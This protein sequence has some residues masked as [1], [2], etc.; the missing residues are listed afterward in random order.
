M[1]RADQTTTPAGSRRLAP[2]WALGEGLRLIR[3]NVREALLYFLAIELAT[4]IVVSPLIT[5]ALYRLLALTGEPVRLNYGLLDLLLEPRLLIGVLWLPVL[6]WIAMLNTGGLVAMT[7]RG[8]QQVRLSVGAAF[9]HTLRCLALVRGAALLK[10]AAYFALILPGVGALAAAIVSG[11]L[12]G[13]PDSALFE[14]IP[15][16][17][18]LV[19]ALVVLGAISAALAL[20]LTVRWCFVF[21]GVVVDGL[22][23]GPAF[24]RSAALGRG[25]RRPL[26]LLI[27]GAALV[28]AATLG[29]GAGLLALLNGLVMRLAGGVST[30]SLTWI[31]ALLVAV[32]V[33]AASVLAWL[34]AYWTIAVTTAAYFRLR[35]PEPAAWLEARPAR[36]PTRV[37]ARIWLAAAALILIVAAALTAPDV[38]RTMDAVQQKVLI[39]A[40]RG[41][42]SRAPENTLA[43]VRAAIE[44]GA[45]LIEIDIQQAADGG[46]VL[47]HDLTLARTTGRPERVWELSTDQLTS[48]DAGSWFG[49]EFAGETIPTLEQVID[50][51]RGKCMLNIEIKL[52]GRERDLAETLIAL[53]KREQFSGDCIVTSLDYAVL[54]EIR[55]IAPE[56]PVGIIITAS[57]GNV[58]SLD[59]DLF[60]V[61]PLIATTGFIARAHRQGRP[62][63]VW[64]LNDPRNMHTAI[65]RG[66][67]G[68][69]S[70]EPRLVRRVLESRTPADDARALMLRLFGRP[71]PMAPAPAGWE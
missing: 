15:A 27:V 31:G 68:I 53:L 2:L 47:M 40:H 18:P 66:A 19:L 12:L 63:H 5:W 62:V 22:A 49:D 50:T 25:R 43:A 69:L 44:D 16:S 13:L 70:S 7:A 36:A 24:A 45:D 61:Q 60:A 64:S 46:L 39:T 4:I 55:R 17:A 9:A 3:R 30:S 41:S 54:T 1:S 35:D 14:I 56:I 28:V 23:L 11:A 8:H 6:A 21:H 71:G 67:D 34:C 26:L 65:D 58:R 32:N 10:A 42:A 20:W 38:R 51:V 37:A 57:I 52:H 48:I 33:G 29:L 59:V